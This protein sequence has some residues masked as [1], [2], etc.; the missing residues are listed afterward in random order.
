MIEGIGILLAKLGF[1]LLFALNF[2]GLL[3]WVER[4]QSAVMQD[5]IGANRASILG[6]R[7]IGLFH[8]IADAVKMFTKE[9]FRPGDAEKFLFTIA[10]AISVFFALVGFAVIPFGDVLYIGGEAINLQLAP[11]N[12]GVLYLF[13]VA[14]MAVYGVVLGAWASRNNFALLGGLRASA[15]MISY[16]VALGVTIIGSLM[17]YQTVD[18]QEIVRWQGM[19]YWGF[20]LQPI[21]FLLFLTVGIAETKRIPF[22]P[23]EG[24]SEIIGYFLEYSGMGFGMYFLTDF[25]ETVMI[26][27]ITVTLFFGGWQVPFLTP[28]GFVFPWGWQWPLAN[29]AVAFLQVSAFTL[30]VAFFLWLQMTIRWTLPRFRYDQVMRLGWKYILPISLINIVVTGFVILLIE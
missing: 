13:A 2:G 12:V 18:L 23:P 30:K 20:M 25:I 15:Q 3:T 16:E 17:I 6:L 21:G 11:L 9:S 8:P 5:R 14:G 19:H 27:A 4:K 28:D 29:W 22:D 10:P 1:V 26:S 7:V 24:E